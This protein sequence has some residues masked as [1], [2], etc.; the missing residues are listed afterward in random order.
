[1]NE[2]KK[3]ANLLRHQGSVAWIPSFSATRQD[4][5]STVL[6]IETSVESLPQLPKLLVLLRLVLLTLTTLQLDFH[7]RL[8]SRF[9]FRFHFHFHF[10]FHLSRR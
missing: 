8:H 2:R 6:V 1:M 7:L 5:S 10:R 9:R 4:L 3:E